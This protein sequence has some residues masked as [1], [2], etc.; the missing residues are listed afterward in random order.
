M[1]TQCLERVISRDSTTHVMQSGHVLAPATTAG[2]YNS[3][4]DTVNS[5]IIS[6]FH[7]VLQWGDFL[8]L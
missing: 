8:E 7:L 1:I 5:I 4:S 3:R 6:D 2:T